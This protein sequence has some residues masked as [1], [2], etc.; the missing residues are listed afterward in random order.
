V[1]DDSMDLLIHAALP[2]STG[3]HKSQVFTSFPYVC[4]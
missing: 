3:R 1:D 2:S 4:L